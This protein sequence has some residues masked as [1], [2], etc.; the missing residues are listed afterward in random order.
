[1]LEGNCL[2]MKQTA[3]T[4]TEIQGPEALFGKQW[5]YAFEDAGLCRGTC[6]LGVPK[7]DWNAI[8]DRITK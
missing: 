5:G 6:K 2:L 3:C 4:H 1:M 7:L 8:M